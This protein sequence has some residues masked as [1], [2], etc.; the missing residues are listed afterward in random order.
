M[1]IGV[2]RSVVAAYETEMRCPSYDVLL[3]LSALYGVST[4]FLLGAEEKR[5]IDISDLSERE[6]AAVYEMVELLRA[7][8]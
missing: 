1:Y 4:D 6:A 7:N 3:R 5:Y 8:H 2:S